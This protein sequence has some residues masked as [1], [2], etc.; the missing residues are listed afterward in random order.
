LISPVSCEQTSNVSE[1]LCVSITSLPDDG[2]RVPET[3]HVCSQLTGLVAREDLITVFKLFI[4]V[5]N[6]LPA[7]VDTVET[8]RDQSRAKELGGFHLHT[9][10]REE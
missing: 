6:V 7:A 3:F 5:P 4:S 9:K 10:M 8:M 2:N 1:T